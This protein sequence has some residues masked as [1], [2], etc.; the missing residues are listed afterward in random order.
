MFIV[1]LQKNISGKSTKLVPKIREINV[2]DLVW[3]ALS[4]GDS[5][6]A[7]WKKCSEF[8]VGIHITKSNP[9]IIKKYQ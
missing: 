3:F 1:L 4:G 8:H 9:G 7:A 2:E 5:V 6:A